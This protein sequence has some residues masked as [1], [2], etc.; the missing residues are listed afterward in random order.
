[1]WLFTRNHKLACMNEKCLLLAKSKTGL[2][3]SEEWMN[4]EVSRKRDFFLQALTVQLTRGVE[5]LER[6]ENKYLFNALKKYVF[7]TY[8]RFEITNPSTTMTTK[9][10]FKYSDI[11]P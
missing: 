7:Q 5:I 8:C 1:M 10:A 2:Y 11:R 3:K 6:V 4:G 9:T